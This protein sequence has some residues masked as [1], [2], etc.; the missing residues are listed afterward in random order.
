M[1]ALLDAEAVFGGVVTV[2]EVFAVLLALDPGPGLW[3]EPGRSA[4]AMTEPEGSGEGKG[5][6]G[7][8]WVVA[9]ER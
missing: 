4:G 1:A 2:V 6:K 9:G 5:K 8:I 3:P 7:A